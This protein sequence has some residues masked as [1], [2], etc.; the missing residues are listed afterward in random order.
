MPSLPAGLRAPPA[1]SPV[2]AL[3]LGGGSLGRSLC[4]L[5]RRFLAGLIPDRLDRLAGVGVLFVDLFDRG[6]GVSACLLEG[7]A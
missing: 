5:R 1:R 3:R 4:R 6:A 2:A 7:I